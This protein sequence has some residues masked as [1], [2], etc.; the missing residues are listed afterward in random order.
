MP[1]INLLAIVIFDSHVLTLAYIERRG[2]CVCVC[3]RERETE[4]E[5]EKEGERKRGRE[6]G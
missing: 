5:G 4:R 3:V 6:R 2:W 1:C